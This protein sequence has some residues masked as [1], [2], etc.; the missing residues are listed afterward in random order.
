M[1][2]FVID[3]GAPANVGWANSDGRH[4]QD[5][6]E[7]IALINAALAAGPVALGFESPLYIP[8]RDE[9]K[10][11]T[12]ARKFEGNRAWSASSGAT[13]TMPGL[14][15][16]TYVFTRLAKEARPTFATPTA[17]FD[18][19]IFE[20]MVSGKKGKPAKSSHEADAMHAVKQYKSSKFQDA[21]SEGAE[22]FNLAAAALQ[23]T[24]YQ[25][26]L[27][28]GVYVVKTETPRRAPR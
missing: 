14:V 5:I 4:G 22:I 19:Q 24:G 21:K 11:L 3:V 16:M 23:R 2:I 15:I 26:D 10:K 8:M 1:S 9:W 20:A 27:S 7:C 6:H 25:A 12:S 18:L 13:V 17:R 28:K